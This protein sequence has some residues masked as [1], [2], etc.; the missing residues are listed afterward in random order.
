MFSVMA[1]DIQ[2]LLRAFWAVP[3]RWKFFLILKW[4]VGMEAFYYM[5]EA[6][7]H[8]L[9]VAGVLQFHQLFTPCRIY[10]S[11]PWQ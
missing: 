9:W 1:D 5:S 6:C 3:F 4:W 8:A 2:M 10:L 7:S 11:G